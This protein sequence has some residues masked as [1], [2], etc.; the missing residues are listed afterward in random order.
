MVLKDCRACITYYNSSLLWFFLHN[1][2]VRVEG[3]GH[4]CNQYMKVN[5][6]LKNI[7]DKTYRCYINKL[8]LIFIFFYI[9][10]FLVLPQA[11]G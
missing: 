10:D 7:L 1:E 2:F 8:S 9:L 5:G 11:K 6:P 3:L 4:I